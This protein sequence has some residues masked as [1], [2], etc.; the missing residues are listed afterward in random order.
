VTTN[1]IPDQP[2]AAAQAPICVLCLGEQLDPATR[3]TC[4]RCLGTG[5]DP[6][7]DAPASVLPLPA[8]GGAR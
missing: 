3:T 8:R 6:D 2:P 4:L 1:T 7:P 5:L